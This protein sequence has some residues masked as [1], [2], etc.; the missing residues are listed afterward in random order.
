MFMAISINIKK[1]IANEELDENQNTRGKV[2]CWS[3]FQLATTLRDEPAD[4]VQCRGTEVFN[5]PGFVAFP[6]AKKGKSLTTFTLKY[7]K[8]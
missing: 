2:F 6:S 4:S 8:I 5:Q 3:K 7:S 1:K